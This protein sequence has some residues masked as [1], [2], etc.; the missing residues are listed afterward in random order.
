M[1]GIIKS[2]GE[3]VEIKS[4]FMPKKRN[5]PSRDWIYVLIDGRLVDSCGIEIIKEAPKDMYKED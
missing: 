5:A 3:V 2:T 4:C 1:K